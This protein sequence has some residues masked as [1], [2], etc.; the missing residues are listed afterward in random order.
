MAVV[1][2]ATLPGISRALPLSHE[3]YEENLIK[4]HVS[5]SEKTVNYASNPTVRYRYNRFFI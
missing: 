5:V 2:R 3:F 4:H 1:R